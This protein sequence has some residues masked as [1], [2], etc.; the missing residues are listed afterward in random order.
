MKGTDSREC[1]FRH[2][3]WGAAIANFTYKHEKTPDLFSFFQA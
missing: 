1:R 2:H 3:R